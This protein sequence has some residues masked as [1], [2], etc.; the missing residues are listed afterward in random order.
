MKPSTSDALVKIHV[1]DFNNNPRKNDI[2]TLKTLKSATEY[3]CI[4]DNKGNGEL[5]VPKG[6]T[7]T[8]SYK[9]IGSEEQYDSISIPQYAGL[10]TSSLTI[11]YDPAKT[12]TLKNVYFDYDKSSLQSASFATLDELADF[13]ENKNF[14]DNRNCRSHR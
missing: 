1:S 3:N 5:L 10:V 4:T 11:K 13:M 2:V 12:I 7:Y 9:T 6:K 8:V 14:D